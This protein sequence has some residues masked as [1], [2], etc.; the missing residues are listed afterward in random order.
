MLELVRAP[1]PRFDLRFDRWMKPRRRHLAELAYPIK[2]SSMAAGLLLRPDI[3]IRIVAIDLDMASRYRQT[4]WQPEEKVSRQPGTGKQRPITL[5][6]AATT[7]WE[8]TT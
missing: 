1:P 6:P 3:M 5:P 4:D 2:E 7:Q 8:E